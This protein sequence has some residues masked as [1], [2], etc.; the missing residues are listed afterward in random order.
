MDLNVNAAWEMGATGEGVLVAIVGDGV[1]GTHAD[2]VDNY[3]SQHSVNLADGTMDVKAGKIGT[4]LA[5]LVVARENN[6]VCGVGVA[7]RADVCSIQLHT[8]PNNPYHEELLAKA[9]THHLDDISVYVFTL[10][11]WDLGEKR[12]APRFATQKAMERGVKNGRKGLG[13]IYVWPSGNGGTLTTGDNCNYNG[14]ANSRFTIAVGALTQFG[15]HPEYSVP[16]SAL[17]VVAPSIDPLSRVGLA[18]DDLMGLEGYSPSDCVDNFG[19]HCG[20]DAA[21]ANVAGV[22][23]LMLS[24]NPG[25]GWRDVQ[26]ILVQTAKVVDPD[27]EHWEKNSAGYSVNDKYG[28]GLVNAAAAV[29]AAATWENIPP[30]AS[31]GSP[32]LIIEKDFPISGESLYATYQL[33]FRLHIEHVEVTFS[34]THPQPGDVMVNL[35]SPSGTKSVLADFNGYNRRL[36]HMQVSGPPK[37]VLPIT[38]SAAEAKFTPTFF[39]HEVPIVP[40]DHSSNPCFTLPRQIGKLIH[41]KVVLI[42]ASPN[43]EFDIQV[44]HLQEVGAAAV[45]IQSPTEDVF[46]MVGSGSDIGTIVIPACMVS[47]TDGTA[48]RTMHNGLR[49]S[50]KLLIKPTCSL[51]RPEIP[52]YD[53]WTFMSTRHWGESADGLWTLE[54]QTREDI[55][56]GA[57]VHSWKLT[58]HG[59]VRENAFLDPLFLD[60]FHLFDPRSGIEADRAWITYDVS[61]KGQTIAI[62]GHGIQ[63]THP[64][65]KDH[66]CASCSLVVEDSALMLSTAYAGLAAGIANNYVCGVGVAYDSRIASIL[67]PVTDRTD[68]HEATAIA[69]ALH[70]NDVYIGL[71]GP[72]DDGVHHVGPGRNSMTSFR[73][74]I[75]KGRKGRGAIYIWS[76]GDGGEIA[77]SCNYDGYANHPYTIAVGAVGQDHLH[78]KY[79]E[80]CAALMTSAPS[81]DPERGLPTCKTADA[82]GT[83]DQ[84]CTR[85][86]TGTD[87][88]ASLVGGAVA[89]M[90]QANP[91]LTW[92]DVQDIIIRSSKVVD[93]SDEGWVTNSAGL[94]HNDKYGYVL[95][96]APNIPSSQFLL[97]FLLLFSPYSSFLLFS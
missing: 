33:P 34:A 51:S 65:I 1:Q 35:Y 40:L 17:L 80:S 92:F 16:C 89:L 25:L 62:L 42:Y 97:L 82:F 32:L 9:F 21:A 78:L 57:K 31:Y 28:F 81:G 74:G 11:P 30:P 44:F 2:I 59:I 5:G 64:E 52:Q 61:G 13:A 77:D 38:V 79:S 23:A 68:V 37:A 53:S 43:C 3:Q 86:A 87:A 19:Q 85:D 47:S 36:C 20:T 10:G 83:L 22:I 7:F 73:E 46:E 4:A 27:D 45:W 70:S 6:D 95:D 50:E 56:Q 58:V 76:A 84:E 48:V 67:L 55:E 91:R 26:H 39:D 88:A 94:M 29:S 66:Y 8:N 93:S 63:E 60:Q 14:F 54:V 90:L 12:R 15:D 49:P 41:D 72:P 24:A 75:E 96:L 71:F 18:T 69:H